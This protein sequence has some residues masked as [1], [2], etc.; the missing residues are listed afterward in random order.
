M[1]DKI[2][3]GRV[4]AERGVPPSHTAVRSGNRALAG[5]RHSSIH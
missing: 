4:P 5:C 1:T 3:Q 2:R